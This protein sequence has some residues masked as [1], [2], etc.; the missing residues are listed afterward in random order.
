MTNDHSGSS[1]F[2]DYP[3]VTAMPSLPSKEDRLKFA[4][5]L[6]HEHGDHVADYIYAAFRHASTPDEMFRWDMISQLIEEILG[7]PLEMTYNAADRLACE[8]VA[9]S[10]VQDV[11]FAAPFRKRVFD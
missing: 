2:P 11:S 3:V 10:P 6:L 5:E 9:T 4:F 8:G 1:D 7:R